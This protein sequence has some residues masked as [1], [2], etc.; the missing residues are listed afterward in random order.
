ME[1]LLSG[2]LGAL[3]AS[4]LSV[5]YQH[6]S[7]QAN[8]RFDVM[9]KAVD[10]FDEL[11]DNLQTLQVYKHQAYTHGIEVIGDE[12]Y[13]SLSNRTGTL[14]KS[15]GVH[16]RVALVYGQNSRE[17]EGFNVLRT[18]MQQAALVLFSSTRETWNQVSEQIGQLFDQDIDSRR[19]AVE[20]QLL[21]SA[22]FSSVL[23]SYLGLKS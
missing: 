23:R 2:L 1:L 19:S 21:R 8:R 11:Y 22:G 12:E 13:Q 3:I 5:F 7:V 15:S 9:L 20:Q 18:K 4:V 14:L 17:L 16:V 6:V 10:Y